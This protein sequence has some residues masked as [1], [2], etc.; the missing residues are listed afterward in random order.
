VDRVALYPLDRPAIGVSGAISGLL[1]F[2]AI[3]FHRSKLTFMLVFWQFKLTAPI[4]VAIWACM[5]AA[6]LWFGVPGIAW[7][8]HLGGLAFG[9]IL[10]AASYRRLLRRRPLLRLLNGKVE[11]VVQSVSGTGAQGSRSSLTPI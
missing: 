9:L 7:E 4:Y 2:Y 11:P 3:L 6:G 10:G 1:G 8:D 5:N